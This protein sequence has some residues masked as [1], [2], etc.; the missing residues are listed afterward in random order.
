MTT[1]HIGNSEQVDLLVCG[2]YVVSRGGR[3]VVSKCGWYVVSNERE[4]DSKSS[5]VV[6]MC[7]AVIFVLVRVYL[8]R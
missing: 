5:R 8:K 7:L 6:G 4:V 3:Y 1:V 2:Q